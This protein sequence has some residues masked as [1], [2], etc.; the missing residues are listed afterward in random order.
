ME[1][2]RLRLA[3][4][5]VRE[6]YD[7]ESWESFKAIFWFALKLLPT[8]TLI[9]PSLKFRKGKLPIF[10][11]LTLF[12]GGFAPFGKFLLGNIQSAFSGIHP[13]IRFLCT[14]DGFRRFRAFWQRC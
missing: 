10:A 2:S 1:Y 9:Q 8:L 11:Q 14:P 6:I 12:A 4:R 13:A 3:R 5:I 7:N